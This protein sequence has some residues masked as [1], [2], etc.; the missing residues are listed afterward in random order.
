MRTVEL[1]PVRA[2]LIRWA[3]E[4]VAGGEQPIDVVVAELARRGLCR[5]GDT[6]TAR[7]L[8]RASVRRMLT[9]PYYRGVVVYDGVEHPG[10]HK[11]LVTPSMFDKV[12]AVLARFGASKRQDNQ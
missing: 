9:N 1:D 10:R 3:F 5:R 7:P 12:R 6:K 11:P 8:S 4:V 2:P